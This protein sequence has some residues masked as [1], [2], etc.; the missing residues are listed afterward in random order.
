MPARD[1]FHDAVRIA[2]EK[3][4]WVIT[5]DPLVLTIGLRSVFVNLGAEKLIA[6]ER[7]SEKIAVEIKSFLGPS[8][9]SDLEVAWGQFFL[10]ARTL[11][12][13]EPDRMLYLAV[14]ETVFQTVFAEEAGLLLLA[15]PGFHLLVFDPITEEII[16]WKP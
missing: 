5:A 2:L 3:D 13:Q 10:Y 11:Q 9:I 8:P 16:Q 1:L 7:G 12:R 4:G 15:E 6:A 14:N